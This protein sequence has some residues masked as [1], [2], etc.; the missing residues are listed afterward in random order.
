MPRPTDRHPSSR[1]VTHTAPAT[2]A[3]PPSAAEAPAAAGS[4]RAAAPDAGETSPPGWRIPTDPPA[5]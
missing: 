3:D 2:I 5:V 4:G 1:P